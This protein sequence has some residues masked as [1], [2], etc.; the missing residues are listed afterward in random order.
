MGNLH[1]HHCISDGGS[2]SEGHHNLAAAPAHQAACV[3]LQLP[4]QLA[5]CE[6]VQAE[7][8]GQS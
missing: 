7:G 3:Q 1:V 8:S 6:S 2:P 4:E 5:V